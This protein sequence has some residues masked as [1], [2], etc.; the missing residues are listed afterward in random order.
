MVKVGFMGAS[1]EFIL[2]LLVSQSHFQGIQF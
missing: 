1:D 2:L